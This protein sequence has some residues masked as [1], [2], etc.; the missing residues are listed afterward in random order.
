[1]NFLMLLLVGLVIQIQESELLGRKA[2]DWPSS[3]RIAEPYWFWMV[4]SRSKIRL[5]H[6]KDGC[7][8]RPFRHYC[9]SLLLSTW[10]C[11]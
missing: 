9:E 10:V 7:G 2:K 1:M 5:V 4:W 6:K 11:A 8:T 3:S